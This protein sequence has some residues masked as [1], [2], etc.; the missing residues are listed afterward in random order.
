[1]VVHS[2]EDDVSDTVVVEIQVNGRAVHVEMLV[3]RRINDLS[4]SDL[5]ACEYPHSGGACGDCVS[6]ESFFQARA[7]L[8]SFPVTINDVGFTGWRGK[9]GKRLVLIGARPIDG[10]PWPRRLESRDEVSVYSDFDDLPRDGKR[11]AWAYAHTA[12]GE[13]AYGNSGGIRRAVMSGKV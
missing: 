13:Y 12:C 7:N 5:P 3:G 4:F 9:R 2:F 11:L 10:K 1:M 6:E 8:S